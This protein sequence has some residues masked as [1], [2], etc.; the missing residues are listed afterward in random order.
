ME[1]DMIGN[2]PAPK[3]LGM[4]VDLIC[5][6]KSGAITISQLAR[7]LKKKNPFVTDAEGK[8]FSVVVNYDQSLKKMIRA[9]KYDWVNDNITQKHFPTERQGKEEVEIRIFSTEELVGKMRAVSFDEV[10]EALERKGYRPANLPELLTIGAEFP[11]KQREFPII[12]LGSVWRGSVGRRIVA[13]LCRGGS[14]RRLLLDWLDDGWDDYCRFA[15]VR[16]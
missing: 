14:E 9:G 8:T 3:V 5:K 7:F 6:L 11:D 4:L 1:K 10:L 15:A 16:K 12:E 13:C 2:V